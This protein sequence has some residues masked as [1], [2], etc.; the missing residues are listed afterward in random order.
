M[1]AE[2]SD[3]EYGPQSSGY[4]A[5]TSNQN[6]SRFGS[7]RREVQEPLAAAGAPP[8]GSS[9]KYEDGPGSKG[10]SGNPFED[11]EGPSAYSFS[12]PPSGPY[13]QRKR[14]RW[15]QFREDHLT[16][17]DWT[18]GLNK[19]LG[20]KSKFDGVPRELALN[21]PEAN[22]I[23]RFEINSVSTGKYG[24]ITFLP[25]FLF[26]E[27]GTTNAADGQPSSRA[28]PISS[29]CS[30]VSKGRPDSLTPACIQ[31]VP[32]VSPTG[33]YTTIV[34]LAVVLIAS[35]VKEI[36]EDLVSATQNAADSRN[37]THQIGR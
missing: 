7:S 23:K 14:S 35:A 22:H 13:A 34:P 4:L 26:C 6:V 11:D 31:Q 17:V 37:G 29:S 3:D 21:D 10:Y 19:L 27:Y 12:N 2:F 30:Q 15:A 25:K 28:R 5:S 1:A 8:A 16:D 33:R 9:G 24:P 18:L 20:R 32:G 36:R